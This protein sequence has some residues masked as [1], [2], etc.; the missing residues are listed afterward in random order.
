MPVL[1][2]GAIVCASGLAERANAGSL[3]QRFI[4][5][6]I[7]ARAGYPGWGLPRLPTARW[8]ANTLGS[9]SR[10]ACAVRDKSSPL[11]PTLFMPLGA[12]LPPRFRS[13]SS[14]QFAGRLPKPGGGRAIRAEGREISGDSSRPRGRV[15]RYRSPS[16]RRRAMR[17]TR[18]GRSG[19]VSSRRCMKG[20]GRV[21]GGVEG[22]FRSDAYCRFAPKAPTISDCS[23]MPPASAWSG[24]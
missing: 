5:G 9:S 20:H 12:V 17:T 4:R 8:G 7:R 14:R 13:L 19:R 11:A 22:L 3:G 23:K 24:P 6:L 2:T 10:S 16:R 1:F 21:P 15:L 18:A